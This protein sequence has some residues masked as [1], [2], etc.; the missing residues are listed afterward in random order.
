M[1]PEV[2]EQIEIIKNARIKLRELREKC[3]H[4]NCHCEPT[5][6]YYS[7]GLRAPGYYHYGIDV[8]CHDCG[9]DLWFDEEDEEYLHFKKKMEEQE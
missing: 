7:N 2:E 4:E 3:P 6:D 9:E 8:Y 1:N 5:E